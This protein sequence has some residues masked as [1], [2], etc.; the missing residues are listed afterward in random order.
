VAAG[1]HRRL[2]IPLRLERRRR[3]HGRS[4]TNGFCMNASWNGDQNAVPG[5]VG[6]GSRGSR[7]DSVLPGTS[8]PGTAERTRVVPG[9]GRAQVLRRAVSRTHASVTRT[10]VTPIRTTAS[11]ANPGSPTS[12]GPW[13]ELRGSPPAPGLGGGDAASV[14][15]VDQSKTARTTEDV[16]TNRASAVRCRPWTS[17]QPPSRFTRPPRRPRSRPRQPAGRSRPRYRR[18]RQAAGGCRRG[19]GRA[20]PRPARE[21]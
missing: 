4:D 19:P 11:S 10:E 16:A 13:P 14:T 2:A 1:E 6:V 17:S 21:S 3:E 20:S 9:S 7:R 12:P 8:I 15:E 18:A 5:A